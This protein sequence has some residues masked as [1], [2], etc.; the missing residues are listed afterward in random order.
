MMLGNVYM[1]IVSDDSDDYDLIRE[2]FGKLALS[3]H[4]GVVA[5]GGWLTT[6]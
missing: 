3:Y 2:R 6:E 1:N 5:R 4:G